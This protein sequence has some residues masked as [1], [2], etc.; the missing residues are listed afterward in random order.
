MRTKI[1]LI[2]MGFEEIKIVFRSAAPFP[3]EIRY[4]ADHKKRANR[5]GV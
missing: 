1:S 3:T 5:P 4:I 2:S